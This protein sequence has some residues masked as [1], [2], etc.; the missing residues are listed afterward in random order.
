MRPFHT[1]TLLAGALL[2][3]T[4]AY[5]DTF[6]GQVTKVSDADTFTMAV[7]ESC[8]NRHCPDQGES[9]RIRLLGIDAPESDQPYGNTAGQR[10]RAVIDGQM[11]SVE[12]TDTD[13]YGR[14][15]GDVYYQGEWVN[16]WL[17]SQGLA[18]V[19]PR[20]TDNQDLFR[21]HDEAR[22]ARAGLWEAD[23]PMPP[24]EW[25]QQ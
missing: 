2:L 4:S 13:P 3:A 19:W 6:R 7:M 22:E 17:V 23:N 10:L 9:A 16:G 12:P 8:D 25:R 14:P 21:W 5:A 24:W 18:W 20:Y 11:V 15:V 1:I